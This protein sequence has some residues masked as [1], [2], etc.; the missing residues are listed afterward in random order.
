[1]YEENVSNEWVHFLRK[2]GKKGHKKSVLDGDAF[3]YFKNELF[4]QGE[5]YKTGN[6]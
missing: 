4:V 6:C 2:T 1:M 3:S 5:S